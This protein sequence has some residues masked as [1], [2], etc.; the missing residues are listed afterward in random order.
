[1][2]FVNIGIPEILLI[3]SSGLFQEGR[4]LRL[5]FR[6]GP[7]REKVNYPPPSSSTKAGESYI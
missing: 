3:V 4:E 5:F 2:S 6:L 7:P 1:M